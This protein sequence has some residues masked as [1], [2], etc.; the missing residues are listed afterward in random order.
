[1]NRAFFFGAL[2]V[3]A[4][5][6][7]S[8]NAGGT[9]ISPDQS[10]ATKALGAAPSTQDD[11]IVGEWQLTKKIIDHNANGKIDEDELRDAITDGEDYLK[12]NADGSGLVYTIKLAGTYQ[13]KTNSNGKKLLTWY[14]KDNKV[15]RK[16]DQIYSVTNNE[17]IFFSHFAGATFSV[18]K[19]L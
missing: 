12:F 9:T 6:I 16:M 10:A 13:I 14:D 17:L 1:M 3:V 11:S 15:L 18:Y 4:C 19:R 2:L 8:K 7:K 5:N